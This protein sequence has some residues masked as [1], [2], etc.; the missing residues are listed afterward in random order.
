MKY[1]KISF[2]F[3]TLWIGVFTASYAVTPSQ[4][5]VLF[6]NLPTWVKSLIT[7]AGGIPPSQACNFKVNQCWTQAG[8]TS[9]FSALTVSRASAETC[10]NSSGNYIQVIN[11]IP[12]IT[13][14]GLGV[15]EARTNSYLRNDMV[16]VVAG[17]PGTAPTN[18]GLSTSINNITRTIIGS[19]VE[20][21]IAYVEVRYAGTPSASSNL[22][23]F[24]TV[25]NTTIAAVYGQTWSDSGFAKLTDGSMTN[26][27]AFNLNAEFDSGGIQQAASQTNITTTLNNS[28]GTNLGQQRYGQART[29]TDPDT[30]AARGGIYITY[31]NGNPIDFTIRIGWP[32][33]ENNSINS[34]VTSATV[35]TG[36]TLY[37]VSA[38]GTM[39]WA[40]AGCS[41][42][43]VLNVTTNAGGV[44]TT[45]NSVT[46]AGSCTTF[47]AAATTTWTPGG[48]L[49]AGDGTATFNLV[50]TNNAALAFATPPIVTSGAAATRA[51]S[52]IIIKNP[53]IFGSLY[54]HFSKATTAVPTGAKIIF[55]MQVGDGTNSN[56][57]S[58]RRTTAGLATS[59]L[60]I[61]GAENNSIGVTT[62]AVNTEGRFSS[63]F[64]AV[65]QGNSFNGVLAT[66]GATMPPIPTVVE[67]GKN[68][69]SLYWNG[70]IASEAVWA[71]QR[72]P[73][74]TLQTVN[75]P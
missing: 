64:E 29:L 4:F 69:N 27:S 58:T 61:G 12:C 21:G 73:N 62:W 11:N 48:G 18:S 51:A 67:I 41:T 35:A 71:T 59:V 24:W 9:A 57:A 25:S 54:S 66:G 10:A 38:T 31:T 36:G 65:N 16:G 75:I 1:L 7:S 3:L 6:G 30:A 19:G 74:A 8:I 23:L 46:T 68:G 47:P 55:L 63:A 39:T 37:G 17:S 49:G 40:G 45:V 2:I 43:P 44:I 60:A 5:V 52:S 22:N 42:N 14:V 34:S 72:L 53:P 15:W 33:Y 56:R 28:I 26:L 50:P 70:T 13:N 20:N 32:Q